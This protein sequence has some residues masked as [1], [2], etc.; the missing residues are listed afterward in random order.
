MTNYFFDDTLVLIKGAG[1]L[2][3]GVAWRLH[4]CGF[5]VVMTELPTPLA[6]RRAVAFA[7]AVYT[8]EHEVEGVTARCVSLDDAPDILEAGEI[9]VLIDEDAAA[10]YEMGP[11]VVVD[12]IVAKTNTGTTMDDAPLV[13]ALGPGFLAGTDCHGVVETNRGHYLGRIY[14]SGEAQADTGTP[15]P[16]PGMEENAS[17]VLRAPT[18]GRLQAFVQIGERIPA[19]E[20]IA[21]VLSPAGEETPILAPFTGVLRGLIHEQVPLR[22]GMKIGD[23]D[24]RSDIR[25]AFTISDKSLAVG[26]GVLEGILTWLSRGEIS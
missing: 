13:I 25:H 2:A 8:G 24:P 20:L 10:V 17:R 16:L 19:G 5:P 6:I 21:T 3:T 26:G 15:G 22:A 23:L 12:A 7:E 4:R 11:T 14:W 1:D 9:P 18:D